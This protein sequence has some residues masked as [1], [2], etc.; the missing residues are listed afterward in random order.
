MR[1]LARLMKSLGDE[2][3]LGI[4]D[5]LS[6]GEEKCV[7]EIK[8]ALGMNQPCVSRHLRVMVDAG[9]LKSRR[10]GLW[11]YYS[12]R[13]DLPDTM[14]SLLESVHSCLEAGAPESVKAKKPGRALKCCGIRNSRKK[15]HE[16]GSPS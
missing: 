3:R 5:I 16:D 2:T 4:L 7:C 13:E 9:L 8:Q 15:G 1:S 11:V 14:R 6:D 12:L 10:Q